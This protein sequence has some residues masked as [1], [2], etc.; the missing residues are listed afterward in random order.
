MGGG[1]TKPG[2]MDVGQAEVRESPTVSNTDVPDDSIP[3]DFG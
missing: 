2:Y 1:L 3:S